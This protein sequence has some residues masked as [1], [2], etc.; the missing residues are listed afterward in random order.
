MLV[1]LNNQHF[2]IPLHMHHL[3]CLYIYVRTKKG[4]HSKAVSNGTK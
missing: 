4:C 2:I 3:I 1:T